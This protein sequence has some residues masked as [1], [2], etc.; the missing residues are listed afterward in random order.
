[1]IDYDLQRPQF[2]PW[3]QLA[4]LLL[5]S[6][7]G[8]L[9]GSFVSIPIAT[10]YLHVPLENLSEAL[11]KSENANLSRVL[12]FVTTFFFMAVPSFIFAR[13]INRKP[14]SYI[15]FN[16]AISGK[17]VFIIIGIMLIG[18]AVSGVLSEVNEMIPISKSAAHYFKGLE[19]E[20]DKQM[21]AI[22][23][24][25]S[26]QD[27]IIS[28]IMIALLPALFEE[29]LF[30][31]S[32]QPVMIGITKNAFVG[33]LITSIL[34][35]AIHMSYYG[36]LPRLALGLIIGY[37]FYFS[38]NL[39]LSVLTH[40]LYNAFGVSQ[41]YA[42]SKQGLLNT[43]SMK[44]GSFPL[45]YGLIAAAALYVIFIFFKR[46]SEVVISMHNL[47]NNINSD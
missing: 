32:L 47:K 23:N 11:L 35:S 9:L 13:I 19:D 46:E 43:E 15:G 42:L 5:L 33:I 39:W 12:Q 36:F 40:F 17:Q 10:A 16:S 34:F 1:M 29:M 28:L 18:L 30:R 3:S 44:D 37:V 45:F 26:L 31:G 25:K 7:V 2:S 6:G 38:K 14:I 41:M 24:M 22:A 8:L 21:F 4:I 20:Y 27:Y